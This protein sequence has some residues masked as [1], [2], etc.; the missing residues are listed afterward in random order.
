MNIRLKIISLL[1]LLLV[2][3]IAVEIAVQRHILMPSFVELEHED[4]EVSM[5]RIRRA[6]DMT[7]ENLQSAAA[8]WGDWADLYTFVQ[9]PNPE[10]GNTNFT[11]IGMH[12]LQVDAILIFDRDGYVV[13]SSAIDLESGESFDLDFSAHGSLPKEFPWGPKLQGT[14]RARG[15]IKTNRGIMMIAAAP[16]LNGTGGGQP[17]GMVMMGRLLSA[18]VVEKI[19]AQAQAKLALMPEVPARF[20]KDIVETDTTTEIYQT[21]SNVYS[22]P[23]M[24]LRVEVPREITARGRH[25][26][27]YASIYL[28]GAA[29]A[30]LVLLVIVLNR[31]VLRP[32]RI[33]TEHAN[34]LGS[35][36]DLT[37]RLNMVGSDE[38]AKL[39]RV[40]DGM[41]ERL[42]ESRALLVDKSFQAGFAELARGVLHNLG[43]A[44]TPLG[45]RVAK[46]ES[47][48]RDAPLADMQMA[49]A[50]IEAEPDSQ[51]RADLQEFLR[52]GVREMAGVIGDVAADAAVIE[53][54]TAV[55]QTALT[56]LMRSTRSDAVV[57]AVRL[58]DLFAQTLEIVPDSC[59]QRLRIETDESLARVGSVNV[60]RT[61]LGL[62][63]QNLIINA[64]DAIRDAGRE[65]GVLRVEAEIIREAD[66]EQLHLQ[67]RDNGVGISEDQLERVFDKG[68]STKSHDTNH[69]I[70]LHWC[71]NA[72][73]SLGG[74]IWAASDGVGRGA[75]MHLTLPL[76]VGIARLGV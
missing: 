51:R 19:G 24:Q 70:G 76:N 67:C 16:I 44:M 59:R 55:V 37:S 10:F 12:H 9:M 36:G 8:D 53:R 17:L 69:G 22:Q 25:A 71:A 38:I 61:V 47:R 63:L 39:A 30:V 2:V 68:F 1:A 7:L 14:A 46:L 72:I 66:S 15:F 57:E 74:R 4:A 48:L 45:V 43:N 6:L 27:T 49:L 62:V 33:V 50:Q 52:L 34:S 65:R 73:H 23:L 18:K 40:F 54:Q 20:S 41:V 75:S 35:G 31:I 3:L 42:A 5:R 64:A 58:P 26:V 29:I 60:A 32:L 13:A 21:F 28:I 11:A 56:E